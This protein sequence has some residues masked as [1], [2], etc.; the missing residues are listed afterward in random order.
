MDVYFVHVKS[1]MHALH[2]H[3]GKNATTNTINVYTN[4]ENEDY[5][6]LT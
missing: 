2:V 1:H 3:I 6:Q 5:S 4:V